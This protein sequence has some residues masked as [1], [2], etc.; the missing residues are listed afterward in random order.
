VTQYT[1]DAWHDEADVVVVGYGYAG[2]VAAIEA[3][4]A[5]ADVLL[6]EKMPDPGGIS[7][8]SGGNVRIVED[9]EEGL[10]HL[11]ATNAETTPDCVLRALAAGMK[12]IPDYFE[13]L[14]RVSGATI[15]RRQADGNYPFPGTRTFGYVSIENIPGFDAERTYPFVSS[16]V[17]IHR[18]AGV[19]LFKVLE[20]NVR[21]RRLRVMLATPARRLITGNGGEIRGLAAERDGKMIA[22]KA[23]RAVVLACGG[24]EA[25]A[26]MQ[27]QFWQ[28]KP[29]LNAAYM[30]NTGDGILMAQDV[31]AALWHMWHYHGVYGFRHPDPDYPFGIRPKRLPDWIPGEAARPEVTVPWIIVDRRGRRYMNEYQPYTQDTSWRAMALLD[32]HSMSYPRIPSYMIMDEPGRGAY[33]IVSPT[34]NDRRFKFVWSE[35]TLREL[36]SRILHKSSSIGE[37]AGGMNVGEQVLATTIAD[38]NAACDA[39][40]DSVHGRPPTSMRKIATPP[41]YWAEVWPICSN[42]HGGPVHDVEQRV[43]SAFGEPI[44]RLFAAGELGGVFG[45]LYMSG[46]NLAECFVGGWTAGRNAARLASWEADRKV[47]ARA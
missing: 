22:V 3:H 9:A 19:R 8:T 31:G 39:G 2:A 35:T 28:E 15:D 29:V 38:W 10:R 44:P 17:P 12:D 20:D 21:S 24:F 30:G 18:A 7:I 14:S 13:K 43:L 26:D 4:D 32:G 36:E 40:E 42:T 37:L 45:H 23:R 34:F 1:L 41:Y 46:G 6:I 11:Q 33:P 25:N 5:G 16:Y 47:G 27:R